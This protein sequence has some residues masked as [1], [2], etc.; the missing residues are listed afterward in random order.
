MTNGVISKAEPP[1]PGTKPKPETD[2]DTLTSI[3]PSSLEDS[4]VYVHCY[5]NNT[6]EDMLIRIWK[7]TFL[8]D[9]AS[10]TKSQ[11]LH[12]EN[13]SIAPVWTQ[14]PIRQSYSFLLIFAGLPKGCQQFDLIEE[15]S[16]PGGF[17]I[18]NISR[19]QTDVY[20]VD[21]N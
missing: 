2:I 12:A 8:V 1:L 15:I 7:T 11:L 21:I 17:F 5:F 10:G 18:G 16:Q 6:K 20:H 19:N 4:H 3:D 14:V 13:I 9:K